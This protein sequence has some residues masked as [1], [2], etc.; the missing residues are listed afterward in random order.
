MALMYKNLVG[1][2]VLDARV[3]T[4]QNT[5]ELH[6]YSHCT[7]SS[8]PKDKSIIDAGMN[9]SSPLFYLVFLKI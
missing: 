5:T 2:G 1:R 7:Q 3:G 4:G 8:L 6:I 9:S